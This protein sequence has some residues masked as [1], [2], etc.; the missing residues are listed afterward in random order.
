MKLDRGQLDHFAV[1]KAKKN[2]DLTTTAPLHVREILCIEKKSVLRN[3]AFYK[4]FDYTFMN[5]SF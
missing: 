3:R 5:N 2:I 1:E 4:I